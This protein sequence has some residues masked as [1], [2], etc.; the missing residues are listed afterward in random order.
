MNQHPGYQVCAAADQ[1]NDVVPYIDISKGFI[2]IKEEP[3]KHGEHDASDRTSHSTYTNY[4]ADHPF[5]EHI[6]YGCKYIRTPGLVRSGSQTDQPDS[7][8]YVVDKPC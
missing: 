1:E 4:R 6:R 5:R 8:P 2:M 7:N 3:D